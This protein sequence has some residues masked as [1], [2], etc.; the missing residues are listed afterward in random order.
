MANVYEIEN[1]GMFMTI[2]CAKLYALVATFKLLFSTGL[3]SFNNCRICRK[4]VFF[5]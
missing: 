1:S 4:Q 3:K 2:Q 5:G